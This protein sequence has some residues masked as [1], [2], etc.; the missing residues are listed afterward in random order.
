MPASSPYGKVMAGQGSPERD[1]ILTRAAETAPR[2][3][4]DFTASPAGAT[5]CDGTD[6]RPLDHGSEML[7]DSVIGAGRMPRLPMAGLAPPLAA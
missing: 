7:V 1:G 5:A 4:V 2:S 6:P 3:G